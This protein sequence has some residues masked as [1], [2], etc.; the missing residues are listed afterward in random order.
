MTSILLFILLAIVVTVTFMIIKQNESELGSRAEDILLEQARVLELQA[1]LEQAEAREQEQLDALRVEMQILEKENAKNVLTLE[2]ELAAAGLKGKAAQDALRKEMEESREIEQAKISALQSQL[3]KTRAEEQKKVQSL[4]SELDK[5]RARMSVMETNV[6]KL[7]TTSENERGLSNAQIAELKKKLSEAKTESQNL[8]IEMEKKKAEKTK[9]S[10]DLKKIQSELDELKKSEAEKLSTL[11]KK[12]GDSETTIE[13]LEDEIEELKN[14]AAEMV[15]SPEAGTQPIIVPD[16]NLVSPGRPSRPERPSVGG[17]RPISDL[18]RPSR[19]TRPSF[20]PPPPPAPVSSCKYEPFNPSKNY[21]GTHPD[22]YVKFCNDLTSGDCAREL[23]MNT[24]AKNACKGEC[25][26]VMARPPP[27]SSPPPTDG[28]VDNGL[29]FCK[30][31]QIFGS[32]AWDLL[33]PGEPKKEAPS[34][35]D[36]LYK[37]YAK[38]GQNICDTD[39]NCKYVTVWRNAGYRTYNTG[40]GECSDKHDPSGSNKSWKKMGEGGGYKP[41]PPKPNPYFDK[42]A[43]FVFRGNYQHNTMGTGWVYSQKFLTG[44]NV[45]EDCKKICNDYKGGSPTNPD[46]GCPGFYIET[47]ERPEPS[48][49]KGAKPPYGMCQFYRAVEGPGVIDTVRD[50]CRKTPWEQNPSDGKGP[51]SKKEMPYA[52][53]G[54]KRGLYWRKRGASD[55]EA[56]EKPNPYFDKNADFVHR[57][58]YRRLTSMGTGWGLTQKFMTGPNIVNDCKKRCNDFNVS[59]IGC[60]GFYIESRERPEPS[61]PKGA[62]PPYALCQAYIATGADDAGHMSTVRDQCRK[63]PWEQNPSDGKGPCS[64]KEGD[65]F[66]H[67]LARGLYWRKKGSWDMGIPVPKARTPVGAPP[68]ARPA[69]PAANPNAPVDPL[70]G[71]RFSEELCDKID[72]SLPGHKGIFP[73]SYKGTRLSGRWANVGPCRPNPKDPS[74]GVHMQVKMITPTVQ[75]S[76]LKDVPGKGR[77]VAKCPIEYRF[78]PEEC[79]SDCEY[80][81]SGNELVPDGWF[82][83]ERLPVSEHG[84]IGLGDAGILVSKH[85]VKYPAVGMARKCCQRLGC[86][87]DCKDPEPG[88]ILYKKRSTVY[89]KCRDDWHGN[90]CAG[91]YGL[92][93]FKIFA[94]QGFD[95]KKK[96]GTYACHAGRNI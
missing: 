90:R 61:T 23:C 3:N 72:P 27:S 43:D 4:Q 64:K 71:K 25:Q 74:K 7:R 66:P 37:E 88:G 33:K 91:R 35:D 80:S 28:Y 20:P 45:V 5:S 84:G 11:Q 46:L 6:E 13:D 54:L 62:K 96:S 73:P 59:G 16:R 75:N 95:L 2:K 52:P 29:G 10:E 67:G 65:Y 34:F 57:G 81:S 19:P 36:P 32:R 30:S 24:D 89:E 51:C 44:P 48:T 50:Q 14:K 18:L 69:A 70:E 15:K 8:Q 47:R 41:P 39:P 31:G 53:H 77:M 93:L 55:V 83:W 68:A 86:A 82:G 79:S 42:N 49:P 1:E 60:P 92:S 58:N 94:K 78:S 40:A 17:A 9:A 38:R 63:T 26:A 21:P 12:L 87:M 56:A 85:Q 76:G 22:N